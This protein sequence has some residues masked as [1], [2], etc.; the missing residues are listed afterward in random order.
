MYKQGRLSNEVQ[1]LRRF[2]EQWT[3]FVDSE[4]LVY[5][6]DEPEY[7][8]GVLLGD[9]GLTKYHERAGRDTWV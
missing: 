8:V 7:V 1:N 3:D 5:D 9:Q 2:T 6:S 4:S